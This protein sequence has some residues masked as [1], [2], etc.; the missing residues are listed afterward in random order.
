MPSCTFSES[1]YIADAEAWVEKSGSRL[2]GNAYFSVAEGTPEVYEHTTYSCFSYDNEF[3]Q[4]PEHLYDITLNLFLYV[5]YVS[6]TISVELG[7]DVSFDDQLC[8]D[9]VEIPNELIS[10]IT[11][12]VMSVSMS[13]D[14]SG[15]YTFIV[16]QY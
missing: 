13:L 1:R 5:G 11:G 9:L 15:T 12:V 14:G 6:Y 2:E 7:Y 8:P 4:L 3:N 16:S 10:S